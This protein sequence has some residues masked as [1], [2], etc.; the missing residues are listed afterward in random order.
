MTIPNL[1]AALNRLAILLEGRMPMAGVGSAPRTRT[2]L[3]P[4]LVRM[5]APAPLVLRPL[6]RGLLILAMAASVGVLQEPLVEAAPLPQQPA[7]G[8]ELEAMAECAASLL[9]E[10]QT[11]YGYWLTSYTSGSEYEAPRQEMNTFLTSML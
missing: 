7:A 11:G 2:D 3:L 1:G 9:R 5:L 6:A 4:I 8:P 10:H